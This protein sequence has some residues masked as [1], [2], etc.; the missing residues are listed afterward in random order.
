[1]SRIL[2]NLGPWNIGNAL[3]VQLVALQKEKKFSLLQPTNN[4]NFDFHL[5]K[6]DVTLEIACMVLKAVSQVLLLTVEL[7]KEALALT[8]KPSHL[9][10]CEDM[11]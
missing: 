2:G 6:K 3:G 9:P 7:S 10:G 8:P 11:L 1:M 5:I 4:K